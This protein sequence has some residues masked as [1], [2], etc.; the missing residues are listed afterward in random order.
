M[1]LTNPVP[2]IATSSV[3]RVKRLGVIAAI[4]VAGLGIVMGLAF[5]F[6]PLGTGCSVSVGAGVGV[7]V[8]TS[9]PE[10]CRS[11]SLVQTQPIWPMPLIAIIVWSVAP[12][13]TA[14]GLIQ[15]LRG[16]ATG[17]A[18]IAAGLIAE[19][20]V[21][22]SFGAAPL[23]VPLVLLPLVGATVLGL[24][25]SRSKPLPSGPRPPQ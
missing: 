21:L 19:G 6:A 12:S 22:I 2:P 11:Y 10:V 13:L 9:G 18:W 16:R 5:L 25:A 17:A 15:R 24:T 20:T 4:F 3:A 14:V 8:T 23:F 7:G 1:A